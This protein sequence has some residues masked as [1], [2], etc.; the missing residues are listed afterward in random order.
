MIRFHAHTHAGRV[1]RHNEDA[2]FADGKNGVFVVA[3]GVGGRAAGEVAS[4]LTI[5]TFELAVPQIKAKLEAYGSSPTWEARNLVLSHLDQ[6][7]QDASKRVYDESERLDRK[8]MTTTVVMMAVANGTAFLAHVGDS[9]A[10]LIRDGLIQQL[11]EDHSMVNELVRAGQMSFEE[12]KASQYRNVITRAV[13]L[14]PNVQADVMSID[15]LPG[16]RVVLCS[17]GLSDP[18]AL[19]DIE[20]IGRRDDVTTATTA[21]VDAALNAGAPDNVTALVVEPDATPTAE[22][23]RARAQIME[24][25]FLFEAL[26]FNARLRVARICEARS[27]QPAEVLAKE[28][29]TGNAMFIIVQGQVEVR[30]NGKAIA[31]LDAGQHFGEMSLIDERPRSATVTSQGPGSV[32]IIRRD[33]LM[34][35]CQR[36]PGLGNQVLMSLATSL[37]HRLRGANHQA[38]D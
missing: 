15:I 1:R 19:K 27:V 22:A 26:P 4:A 24:S 30:R 13:G 32:M 23:A 31:T 38:Q 2:M 16:D 10:Y 12:A 35:L 20:K 28:G 14:Y 7:C 36:E 37:V 29:D 9:R 11:T 34:E 6:V 17:D 8:G 25:L 21:L 5:D 33:A 3:D 18:V